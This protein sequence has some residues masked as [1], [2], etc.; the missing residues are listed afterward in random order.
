ML[1]PIKQLNFVRQ[2]LKGEFLRYLVSGSIAFICDFSVLVFCTE[3]LGA[4][5]LYSN[6]AAYTVGF[7]LSYTINTK[8][9]FDH[10]RFD[11]NRSREFAY[12]TFIVLAGLG[13]S[14]LVI[15]LATESF[16]FPYMWSKI[17]SV[18]FVFLFNFGAKKWLLFS[19][20]RG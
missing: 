5:Y 4:H 19:P 7:L 3:V 20:T 8:W 6:I 16:D 2:F 13:V 10:R 9:V 18:F 14:E 12:F 11:D 17:V 1:M 15:W